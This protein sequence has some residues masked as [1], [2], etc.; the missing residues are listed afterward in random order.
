MATANVTVELEAADTGEAG[1]T[2]EYQELGVPPEV[3]QL[4]L[5]ELLLP[6][7]MLGLWYPGVVTGKFWFVS[8][9]RNVSVPA[10]WDVT[11]NDALPFWA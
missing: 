9:M 1:Y 3:V 2:S 7:V 8:V 4:A 11:V 10:V 6:K 5:P